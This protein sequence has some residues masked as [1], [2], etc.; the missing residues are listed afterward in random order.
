[1]NFLFMGN[2]L[3]VGSFPKNYNSCNPNSQA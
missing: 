2:L 3:V 1:M